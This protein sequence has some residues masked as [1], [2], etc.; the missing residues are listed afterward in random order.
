MG[1]I[2]KILEDQRNECWTFFKTQKDK[3]KRTKPLC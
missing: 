1:V 2:K 3:L